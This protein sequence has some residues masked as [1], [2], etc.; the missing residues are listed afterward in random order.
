MVPASVFKYGSAITQNHHL[1]WDTNG[2]NQTSTAINFY[3]I[4]K[5][6]YNNK[7]NEAINE[8]TYSKRK[9]YSYQLLY[10]F[11]VQ[12]D[13]APVKWIGKAMHL[14][15]SLFFY[16]LIGATLVRINSFLQKL[17]M[18]SIAVIILMLL[19]LNF[20]TSQMNWWAMHLMLWLSAYVFIYQDCWHV[21]LYKNYAGLALL[22]IK[23]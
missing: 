12:I 9:S 14:I 19:I 15:L 10:N 20:Y 13:V 6:R 2:I 18:F 7:A 17:S 5:E 1:N 11:F 23:T 22:I 3:S 16:Y 8:N 21:S 4:Y